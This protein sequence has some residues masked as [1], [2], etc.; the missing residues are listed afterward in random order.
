MKYLLEHNIR[1]LTRLLVPF[2]I[3]ITAA[4]ES[5]KKFRVMLLKLNRFVR[6]TPIFYTFRPLEIKKKM[7]FGWIWQVHRYA[8][9]YLRLLTHGIL[10]QR[11][12]E[13]MARY[14]RC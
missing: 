13:S 14:N 4:T 5:V 3:D 6:K 2:S 7:I 9:F 1:L 12:S 11:F 10:V 8:F